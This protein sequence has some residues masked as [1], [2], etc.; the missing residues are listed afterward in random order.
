MDRSV[1]SASLDRCVADLVAEVGY[2]PEEPLVVGVRLPQFGEYFFTQ[3]WARTGSPLAHDTVLYTASLS[4]QITAACL[5]LLVQQGV[6]HVDSVLGRWLP[7]LPGWASSVRLHHLLHHAGGLPGDT[8]IDTACLAAGQIDRTTEGVLTSLASFPHLSAESGSRFA[9]S[10]AG[11]VCLAVVIE[12]AARQ[13]LPAFAHE[14]LFDP[15][16]MSRTRYWPGPAPH[17]PGAAPLMPRHPAPLSLGDGGVWSSAKDLLRWCQALN[18]NE[19]H[20]TD[21]VQSPGHLGDGTPTGYAWGMGVR[22]HIGQ[23]IYRHGG[24]WQS[25]RALLTRAPAAGLSL[26]TIALADDTER[27]IPLTDNL[28]GRLIV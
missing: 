17:P 18:D 3:G 8:E 23:L 22:T 9:Y 28:L 13:P 10:N 6:L 14:H 4:K 21:L 16:G 1:S 20:L 25:L 27:R 24:G 26:V 5:A 2:R 7:E 12:R 15:L 11:Y 19:L